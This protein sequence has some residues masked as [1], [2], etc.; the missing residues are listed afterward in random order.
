MNFFRIKRNYVSFF[1]DIID[2][3]FFVVD[4]NYTIFD[5][6]PCLIG[7]IKKMQPT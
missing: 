4:K 1:K 3:N 2:I 5:K 7:T 6:L